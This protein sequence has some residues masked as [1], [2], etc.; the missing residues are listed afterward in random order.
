VTP[1]RMDELLRRQFKTTIDG[2]KQFVTDST[3]ENDAT[4]RELT[5]LQSQLEKEQ[6][7]TSML[8]EEKR[9]KGQE[10]S[11]LGAEYAQLE[12]ELGDLT[13]AFEQKQR[14]LDELRV[15]AGDDARK[16]AI[17]LSQ[18]Q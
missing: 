16:L 5:I 8:D 17:E 7:H 10:L 2:Y 18:A 15:Q 13:G 6:Y 11:R 1:L 9:L 4:Q 14:E 3:E 12:K